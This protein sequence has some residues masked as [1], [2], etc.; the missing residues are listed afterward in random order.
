MWADDADLT[1]LLIYKIRTRRSSAHNSSRP[2]GQGLYL[3][4][5]YPKDTP[6]FKNPL[7]LV[8]AFSGCG[9][10]SSVFGHGIRLLRK[11]NA[12]QPQK[13]LEKA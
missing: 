1:V 12:V 9:T 8:H 6:K 4:S 2:R 10:T 3:V 13:R 5:C 7:L 11:S